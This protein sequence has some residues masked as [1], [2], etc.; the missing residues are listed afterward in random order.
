MQRARFSTKKHDL[1]NPESNRHC[2][3]TVEVR[4]SIP[5]APTI[6]NKGLAIYGWP[7]ILADSAGG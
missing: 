6:K 7:L 5:L 3:D 1:L 4:G 2:I